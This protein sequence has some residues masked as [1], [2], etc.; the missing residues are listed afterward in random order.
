MSLLERSLE[1][2][3]RALPHDTAHPLSHG[4]PQ[5]HPPRPTCSEA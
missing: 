1:V 4:L 5:L 2:R 3:F